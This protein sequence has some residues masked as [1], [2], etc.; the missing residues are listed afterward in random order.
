M[1]NLFRLKSQTHFLIFTFFIIFIGTFTVWFSPVLIGSSA[2][3]LHTSQEEVTVGELIPPSL[4][5]VKDYPSE[6]ENK[7]LKEIIELSKGKGDIA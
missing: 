6:L 1:E 4:K 3:V 7:T 2:S 5:R